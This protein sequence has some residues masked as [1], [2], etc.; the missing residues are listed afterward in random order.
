MPICFE[1][2]CCIAGD[3]KIVILSL[4]KYEVWSTNIVISE[5]EDCYCPNVLTSY[6]KLGKIVLLLFDE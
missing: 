1:S 5:H 4:T 2:Y 3:N 6:P